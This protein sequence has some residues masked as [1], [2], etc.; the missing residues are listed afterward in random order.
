ME[1]R[2]RE[3]KK[4]Q[5][6]CFIHSPREGEWRKSQMTGDPSPLS[7]FLLLGRCIFIVVNEAVLMPSGTRVT[8]INGNSVAHLYRYYAIVNTFARG[9]I[10]GVSFASRRRP[11]SA[12]SFHYILYYRAYRS[13]FQFFL[14]SLPIERDFPLRCLIYTRLRLI[15]I[16]RYSKIVKFETRYEREYNNFFPC[17]R[18]RNRIYQAK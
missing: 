2:R 15:R 7:S 16:R 10:W 5:D 6:I 17:T 4:F 18:L 14:S 12:R 11:F 3:K 1:G 9:H 8:V 13:C